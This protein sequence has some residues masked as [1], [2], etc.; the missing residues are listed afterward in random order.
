M[1]W[2]E[3]FIFLRNKKILVESAPITYENLGQLLKRNH[4]VYDLTVERNVKYDFYKEFVGKMN[5]LERLLQEIN[6][7]YLAEADLYVAD[8]KIIRELNELIYLVKKN[9]DSR[10]HRLLEKI[11]SPF[12]F[13]D[14]YG[15]EHQ[16]ID[17]LDFSTTQDF[18]K[19]ME[20]S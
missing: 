20:N 14:K 4:Y 13:W 7:Y 3:I 12:G 19:H 9:F 10:Y 8:G 1:I 17:D 16:T 15:L 5:I 18:H 11:K 6:P 2:S